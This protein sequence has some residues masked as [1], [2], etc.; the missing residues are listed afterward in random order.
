MLSISI[1]LSD[2]YPL[3]CHSAISVRAYVG[4]SRRFVSP[5]RR[6]HNNKVVWRETPQRGWVVGRAV[7]S[8]NTQ[9]REEASEF[10][11]QDTKIYSIANVH[12]RTLKL[13]IRSHHIA[14][15]FTPRSLGSAY[16]QSFARNR[17]SHKKDYRST[18]NG[19]FGQK[20]ASSFHLNR[21]SNRS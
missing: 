5:P 6:H 14:F 18:Y 9:N 8:H 13:A 20:R 16:R 4:T 19:R 17:H 10:A 21:A 2:P 11:H 12:N 1:A 7:D 15:T 3:C